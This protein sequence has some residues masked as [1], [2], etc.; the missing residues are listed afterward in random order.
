MTGK[1][2]NIQVK[3]RYVSY[4]GFLFSPGDAFYVKNS[5]L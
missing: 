3:S 4:I 2:K 5:D 1:L